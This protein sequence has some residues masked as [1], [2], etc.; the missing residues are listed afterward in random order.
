MYREFF[1]GGIQAFMKR[2]RTCIERNGDYVEKW[3]SC[4]ESICNIQAAKKNFKVF[5]WLALVETR[6]MLKFVR[7]DDNVAIAHNPLRMR[8]IPLMRWGRSDITRYVLRYVLNNKEMVWRIMMKFGV[9][10]MLLKA[11]TKSYFLIS[12]TL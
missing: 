5:I 7:C 12:H 3:Q 4:T 2:W 6:R 10:F 1:S 8:T 11:T 9:D